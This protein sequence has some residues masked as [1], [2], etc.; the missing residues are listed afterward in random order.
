[1]L[2]VWSSGIIGL[3]K[4][5][6]PN[7]TGQGVHLAR[8]RP[9]PVGVSR[10]PVGELSDHDHGKYV[11][12]SLPKPLA[13]LTF[14]QLD[15][16]VGIRQRTGLIICWSWV[17]VPPAPPLRCPAQSPLSCGDATIRGASRSA[18]L[19]GC[20]RS[21]AASCGRF[22]ANGSCGRMRKI[23][24]QLGQ[25]CRPRCPWRRRRPGALWPS[26]PRPR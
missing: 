16:V 19:C 24:D 22:H 18:R 15:G 3:G 10:A 8:V 7:P 5:S 26:W 11:V 12:K 6:R 13:T 4:V 25:R 14:V 1:M 9:R 17:R 21:G 20:G 23:R 2:N